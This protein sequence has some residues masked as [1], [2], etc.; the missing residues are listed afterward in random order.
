MNKRLVIQLK[1]SVSVSQFLKILS[2]KLS[3]GFCFSH[4]EN[5]MVFSNL[6]NNEDK[7]V[8]YQF[9]VS[10]HTRICWTSKIVIPLLF[11]MNLNL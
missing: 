3:S 7:T 8:F 11:V 10:N 5:F 6:E 9:L 4:F 2:P 1:F